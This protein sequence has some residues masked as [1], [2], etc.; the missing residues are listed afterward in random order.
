[1][2]TATS[3]P[4]EAETVA[5]IRQVAAGELDREELADWLNAN[6]EPISEG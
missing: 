1:L 4:E 2:P 6:S 3:E 5:V